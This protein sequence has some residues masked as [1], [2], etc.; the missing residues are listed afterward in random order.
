MP[1]Y[2]TRLN[3]IIKGLKKA[4]KLHASQAATLEKILEDQKHVKVIKKRPES[5]N[6][7][8]TKR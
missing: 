5:R 7:K 3:K 8:K 4:S 6:R 1:H 2:T